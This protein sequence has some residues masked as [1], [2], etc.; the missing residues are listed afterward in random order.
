[1][2]LRVS[3]FFLASALAALA[4]PAMAQMA[5]TQPKQP[6]NC[7]FQSQHPYT[8]EFKVTQVQTLANGTTITHESKNIMAHDSA[9]RFMS[10]STRES[11]GMTGQPFTSGSARDPVASTNTHWNSQTK[12]AI[13]V[14][15]PPKDQQ[16]GCWS[17]EAG[18]YTAAY[19]GSQLALPSTAAAQISGSHAQA[20]QRRSTTEDLG[21]INILGIEGHGIRITTTIPAGQV[22]ND[23]PIIVTNETW[24]AKGLGFALRTVTDDP[25]SGTTTNE[26]VNL[27]RGDPDPALFQP[28]EGYEVKTEE[29]HQVPCAQ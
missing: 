27:T 8:A 9:G 21:T 13:V 26:L 10:S 23:Q 19:D 22:G 20:L 3:R 16:H 14:R 2:L 5:A 25:R 24:G 18:N 4:L 29:L 28:P 15:Y 6:C 12:T 11:P 17:S 7:D 1:M